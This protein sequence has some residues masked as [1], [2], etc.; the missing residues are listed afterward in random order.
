MKTNSHTSNG[1]TRYGMLNR[2]RPERFEEYKR[3]HEAVWPGVLERI[4]ASNMRNYTIYHH[5]GFL[6]A[7]FE[8]WGDDFD[9]DMKLMA[10]DIETRRWWAIMEPMQNPVATR[11]PGQWWAKMDEVFHVD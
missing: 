7:S 9:A 1:Y 3:Y 6:F 4:S 10:T 5:D 2:V 11:Q 8:Y